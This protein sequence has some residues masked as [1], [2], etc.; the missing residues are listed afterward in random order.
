MGCSCHPTN[1]IKE[2]EDKVTVGDDIY[3]KVKDFSPKKGGFGEVLK[4]EKDESFYALK[5]IKIEEQK[6]KINLKNQKKTK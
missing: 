1:E 5:K 4:L 6:E 2:D 3:Y